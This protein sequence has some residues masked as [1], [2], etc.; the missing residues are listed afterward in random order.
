MLRGDRGGEGQEG[1]GIDKRRDGWEIRGS[2][3]LPMRLDRGAEFF[4]LPAALERR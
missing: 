2:G 4:F 1:R 3:R